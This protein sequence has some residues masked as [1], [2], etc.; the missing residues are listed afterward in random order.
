M[1]RPCAGPGGAGLCARARAGAAAQPRIIAGSDVPIS[2]YPFQVQPGASTGSFICGGSIR[3]A[4]HIITAAHCV[5]PA[6]RTSPQPAAAFTV[7][8]GSDSLA[9]QPLEGVASCERADRSTGPSTLD[10]SYDVAV[11]TLSDPI[12][13]SGP[14]AKAIPLVTPLSPRMPAA[15]S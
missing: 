6:P 15:A 1:D 4:T 2:T 10:D 12:D 13:L 3:D 5:L 8:Y 14:N 9:A 11:L 7:G